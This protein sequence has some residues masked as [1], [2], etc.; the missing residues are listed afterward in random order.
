MYAYHLMIF[1][2]NM[3]KFKALFQ[4]I[5]EAETKCM[6]MFEMHFPFNTAVKRYGIDKAMEMI[7]N[8]YVI[9]KINKFRVP[10]FEAIYKTGLR[11]DAQPI[12]EN[13]EVQDEHN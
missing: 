11:M 1:A 3:P 8:G 2:R 9:T 10:H 12:K 5:E 13:P 7:A 6:Q 4:S